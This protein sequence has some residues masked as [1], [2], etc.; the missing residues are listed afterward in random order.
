MQSEQSGKMRI[1]ETAALWL[2]RSQSS[3]SQAQWI[4]SR[5]K[6]VQYLRIRSHFTRE[7]V[8]RNAA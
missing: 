3:R 1:G 2:K 8:S 5:V 7:I 4:F 6:R